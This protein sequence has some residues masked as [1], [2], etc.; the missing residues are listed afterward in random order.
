MQIKDKA[1]CCRQLT[2]GSQELKVRN[3]IT[4]V[5]LKQNFRIAR[6]S[7]DDLLKSNKKV[8]QY[9]SSEYLNGKIVLA[10]KN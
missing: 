6:L 4:F 9:V 1:K 2:C 3:E 7:L 5:D 8:V 10:V